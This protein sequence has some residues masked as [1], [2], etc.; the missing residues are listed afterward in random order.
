MMDNPPPEDKPNA[1]TTVF[2]LEDMAICKGSS[3]STKSNQQGYKASDI[4][5]CANG[6]I[7]DM[8]SHSSGRNFYGP[9]KTYHL[10]AGRDATI[11]LGK[12]SLN[13]EELDILNYDILDDTQRKT[14]AEWILRFRSKYS[15]CGRLK[16]V[17]PLD[18]S[19]FG[20]A[21]K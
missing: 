8:S 19:S 21:R 18:L 3:S 9:G 1:G 13:S 12:L 5:V 10:F 15:F 14:L 6:E 7:Y 17:K 16:D 4:L 20:V 2:S 11:A